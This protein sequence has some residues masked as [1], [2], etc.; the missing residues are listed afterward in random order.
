MSWTIVCTIV[1]WVTAK[2]SFEPMTL[3]G[4]FTRCF[5]DMVL[6]AI[7]ITVLV[8]LMPEENP[9]ILKDPKFWFLSGTLI[10]CLGTLPFTALA[11]QFLPYSVGDLERVW[12]ILWV[13]QILDNIIYATAFFTA[14]GVSNVIKAPN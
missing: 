4:T 12:S 7:A 8:C 2:W 6:L 1:I 11:N 5:E 10:Y 3:N 14:T 9:K 13:T